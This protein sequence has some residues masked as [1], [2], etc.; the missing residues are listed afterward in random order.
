LPTG[1]SYEG[2]FNPSGQM[3]GHGT[4]LVPEELQRQIGID[5]YTG[6]YSRGLRS[7]H[8]V[9]NFPDG[10]VYEGHFS[11]NMRHGS[12][13]MKHGPHSRYDGPWA[14]DSAGT[15][16][17]DMSYPSGHRYVGDVSG[18]GRH[19]HGVLLNAMGGEV[20]DGYWRD[21]EA[22]G[23]GV[24]TTEEG[25]YNGQF[26]AGM[27]DGNG[28]FRWSAGQVY[29]GQFRADQPQGTGSYTETDGFVH[30]DVEV[31]AFEFSSKRPPPAPKGIK[32]KYL[33]K[34]PPIP[35]ISVRLVSSPKDWPKKST[36]FT[37]AV[38]FSPVQPIE[39]LPLNVPAGVAHGR[40]RAAHMGMEGVP[41]SRWV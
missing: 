30:Q 25:N 34:A 41:G 29:E 31:S 10:A 9:L 21:D 6:D 38:H 18:G 17:G 27:K 22:H 2:C 36:I 24:I 23:P 4:L 32:E 8:G 37:H 14:N 33:K 40:S 13:A 1:I 11:E 26:S 15:G 28:R 39:M 3:H 12:G 19:G 7:G 16:E 5:R 35:K 20:F